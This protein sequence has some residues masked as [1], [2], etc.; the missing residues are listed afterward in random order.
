[1]LFIIDR[2][3]TMMEQEPTNSEMSDTITLD[4][5]V[6][7]SGLTITKLIDF[8][9]MQRRTWYQ[10]VKNPRDFTIGEIEKLTTV[11]NKTSFMSENPTQYSS[12]DIFKAMTNQA[13]LLDKGL[14]P[15]N[16]T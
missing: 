10:R 13:A 9:G 4:Y 5:I 7:N 12:L 14:L 16:E 15:T 11:L 3:E 8:I 1:M 2:V 6:S